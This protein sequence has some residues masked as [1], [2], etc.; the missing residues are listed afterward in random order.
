MIKT[1]LQR[2]QQIGV[3]F[4]LSM[5]RMPIWARV[6]LFG[7]LALV[8]Y[9][10]WMLPD[11]LFRDPYSG[12][13][14]D[15]DGELLSASIAA[16][17]QWRF[18]ASDLIPDKFTAC[19]TTFE[20]RRFFRH[21]GVDARAIIRAAWKNWQ[22]GAI[23]EGG[24]TLTMQVV[25][26]WK[27]NQRRS[28]WNKVEEAVYAFRLEYRY[29]KKQI[30]A[31]YAAHAPFGG[32]VVGLE[33]AAWR[34]YGRS[35]DQL[36][37]GEM[38]ALAVLPNAPALVHPGRNRTLL[39][40]KRNR[41]LDALVHAG[42]LDQSSAD[43]AKA[44]SL[45]GAPKSLPNQAYHLLQRMKTE[46]RGMDS[47]LI[48]R[49]TLRASLQRRANEVI[50]SHHQLLRG[51]GINNIA[52][53]IADV[54]SG[55]V[56]AY[57][58][59]HYA[60]EVPDWESHVDVLSSP[61]SPGST[62]KPMLY[63]AAM[64][65]GLISPRSWLADIPT[66]LGGYTPENFD[67]TYLGAVSASEALA[68]SLNI[69]AVRL[70]QQY[71]YARFY[72]LLQAMG[73]RTLTQPADH[74]G[75]SLILGG[76]EVTPWDLAGVYASMVRMVEGSP[77]A[78]PEASGRFFHPLRYRLFDQAIS[79]QTNS[80][81]AIDAVS[82]WHTFQMMQEVMR[83]GE[84]ALWQ[85]FG[86]AAQV[87]WKTGTSFGF[88]DAWSIGMNSKY[89]VL[90][91][92]GNADGEGRAGLIGVQT[93]APVMFDLFRLLPA[94][95]PVPK[96]EQGFVTLPICRSTGFRPSPDC[97][98]VDTIWGGAQSTQIPMCNW[99]TRILTDPT[100]AFRVLADC[101][102][103]ITPETKSWLVLPP[104]MAYYYQQHQPFYR[105][106]PPLHPS[107]STMVDQVVLDVI[108]PS[109]GAQLTIPKE[110]T[111]EWGKLIFTATHSDPDANLFWSLD[112][113]PIASTRVPHQISVQ[114][115]AGTHEL[116]VVDKH[117]NRVTR[118]FTVRMNSNP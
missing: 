63:A 39:Q 93:A 51:N 25:R 61:R 37:W 67:R 108:Y 10:A 111:G 26:L 49:S 104:A 100:G 20:D 112:Q 50:A 114:P 82:A 106:L 84:E 88:R 56:L 15:R 98:D 107:C 36:S 68:R 45:P 40:D 21:P 65:D 73:I 78:T 64:S 116:V 86:D 85:Q 57:V 110:W 27:N 80:S 29:S 42:Y 30:L 5:K 13:L 117:G 97:V 69:P 22:Q 47:S 54:S 32:N 35:A 90:V 41:L 19:I 6:M 113:S 83:P 87:S 33:A 95:P 81:V 14:L 71:K 34:Y 9:L 8:L 62:L 66:Q 52:A 75:L 46:T 92:T 103:G 18:P 17:G 60:P 16:D 76:A 43:L 101:A 109:D 105:P 24:S 74:Y 59:N 38:A 3:R 23:E 102:V 1:F 48:C 11:R 53:L 115:A 89:L 55:Q 91:W 28:I 4:M 72:A 118:R 31:L 44:E 77:S 58:G 94:A 2:C 70:L 7:L 12:V 96:P 79:R 99:H